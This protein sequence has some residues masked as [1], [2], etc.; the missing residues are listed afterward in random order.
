MGKH[1]RLVIALVALPL[2]LLRLSTGDYA[3]PPT[4]ELD[5]EDEHDLIRQRA[6][7]Y[8]DR[9]GDDG[10]I[11]PDERLQKVRAEYSRRRLIEA[12]K[13]LGT[14]AI[15]GD[16]WTS[17]GPT[18][19]AGRATAIAVHPTAPGTVYIGAAGGGVWK[20]IDAGSTW[21]PLTESINDLSVGAVAL[22]PSDPNTVYLG[23]GEGGLAIDFIPGIGFLKSVDGG[24]SWIF[25]TSVLASQFFRI[26]VHPTN[27]QVLVVG[28][29]KGGWRST[30]GGSTWGQVIDPVTY[31]FV[32][33]IVRHP[34]MPEVLYATTWDGEQWCAR[35]GSANCKASSA[36]VLKSTDDGATWTEKSSGIPLSTPSTLVD[37]M[38]IAMS[39]TNPEVMYL[40]N[41]MLDAST[42]I[43]TSHIF[44]T[45]DGGENWTDLPGIAHNSSSN[46]SR[47]MASQVWYNNTIVVSPTDPNVALAGGTLYV[48][49]SDGGNTWT[50][51][52]FS[53]SSSAAHVDAHDLRYQGSTLYIANDGGI[54]TSPDDGI[55]SVNRNNGLVTRQ[56]YGVAIDSVN[57]NRVLG[58]AQDN[59]TTRRPDSGGTLWSAVIGGD[60]FQ[61]GVLQNVPDYSYG[62][63]QGAI[64]ERTKTSGTNPTYTQITPPYDHTEV[65]PFLSNL[66]VDPVN[67]STVYTSSYRLWRSTTGGDSWSALPITTTD[68]ST[69]LTTSIISGFSIGRDGS[70]MVARTAVVA[71][72]PVRTV[73]LS[74]DGGNTWTSRAQGLSTRGITNLQIDPSNSQI[75]YLAIA[76]TTGPSVY[77][78]I[79]QGRNWTPSA[80]GLPSFS[81]QVIRVD[82]TDSNVVYCGTDVGVYRS[83]DQGVNWSHFG[84]GLPASS[85][86]DMKI[87]DDGTIVRVA[88]HGR[89]MWELLP[90]TSGGRSVSPPVIAI[91]TPAHALTVDKGSTVNFTGSITDPDQAGIA[92]AQWVF[93]DTW[94]SMAATG[95][96]QPGVSHTFN[97]AGI[98]PVTLSA[99]NN[100]GG[101]GA[102]SLYVTVHEPFEVCSS[103]NVIPGSGPFPVIIHTSNET[104][105]ISEPGDPSPGCVQTAAGMFRPLWFEFTPQVDG[106]YEFTSCGSDI[107]VVLSLWTGN[108]CGPYTAID[109]G[110]N[111]AASPGSPCYRT[112]TADLLVALKGGQ[113]YRLRVNAFNAIEVGPFT[114]TVNNIKPVIS[115]ASIAGKNL[116]VDG[117]NFDSGAV[118]VMDG[119]DQ[120]TLADDQNPTT[121][122][123]GK[124][125]GKRI[126]TGQ[127]VHLQV[128]NPNGAISAVFPFTRN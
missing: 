73:F 67:P 2:F 118:I 33:D 77:K 50:L 26:S 57:R 119:V 11:D 104:A 49:T 94:E 72:I 113:T 21:V 90:S 96:T 62:T 12:S 122:L 115:M 102:A 51:A 32:T 89:G 45:T 43:F 126:A 82:P 30:D 28:T 20:T 68:G 55:T 75:A 18:N 97:N 53:S 38:S 66:Q 5:V 79:D 81:A 80:I 86:H 76:G 121:I 91:T 116:I 101:R 52:P 25:P 112:R 19:G 128:R 105:L 88:T 23:T 114:L 42:N 117:L 39:Q 48:R 40:A 95:S 123:I 78:T 35:S 9:H 70:I 24:A 71:G 85:V 31:P 111:G 108:P 109:G 13:G 15:Q 41:A 47:F 107:N 17:I 44:K 61:C 14:E 4:Q 100:L 92:A 36:R 127:M 106:D 37:R 16:T 3:V 124:K 110:C 84:T 29:N 60:G 69:W 74:T 8:L 34:T 103:P 27:A 10:K 54:W 99:Q 98:F 59:G 64:I 1:R 87:S 83:T 65:V 46:I 120:H 93:P 58:G 22:A 63:I 56:Y 125:V 7:L 6:R